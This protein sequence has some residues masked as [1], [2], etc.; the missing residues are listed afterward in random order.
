M[1]THA[2]TPTHHY[3]VPNL[4]RARD[5]TK[6]GNHYTEPKL[7]IMRDLREIIDLTADPQHGVAKGAAINSTK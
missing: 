2:D 6:S 3:I 1:V 4:T 7:T 5:P